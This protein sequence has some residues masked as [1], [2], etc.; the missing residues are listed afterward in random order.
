MESS[1]NWF[2][3]IDMLPLASDLARRLLWHSEAYS[4][5]PPKAA[6]MMPVAYSSHG[7]PPTPM[8]RRRPSLRS[9]TRH[10]ALGVILG[11]AKYGLP[12][13]Y[14]SAAFSLFIL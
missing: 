11:K 13:V 5:H 6:G 14:K 7:P 2:D 12:L 8:Q 3:R 4:P 9:N 1:L 10:Q